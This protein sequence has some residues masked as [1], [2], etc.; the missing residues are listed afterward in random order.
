MPRC[1]PENDIRMAIAEGKPGTSGLV[2]T[3]HG[4][5]IVVYRSATLLMA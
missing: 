1:A 4:K 5:R 3:K 2:G